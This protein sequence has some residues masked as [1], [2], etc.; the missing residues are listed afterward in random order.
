MQLRDAIRL[1]V[2]A[3]LCAPIAIAITVLVWPFWGWFESTS[4]VEAL[5]HSGPASWCYL[6]TY[7]VLIGLLLTLRRR[8]ARRA[9]S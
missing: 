2:W 9:T 3:M 1:L 6:T 8:S 5:G 4:G 7:A